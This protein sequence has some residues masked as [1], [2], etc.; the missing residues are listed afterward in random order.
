MIKK[1][2]RIK[3]MNEVLN[4]VK[5]IQ[6][7]ASLVKLLLFP[8]YY[9]VIKLYAWE[10]PFKRMVMGIREEELNVLKASALLNAGSSFTWTC[11]P[12]LVSSNDLSVSE[13][14]MFITQFY[15]TYIL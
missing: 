13:I 14:N 3:L 7:T 12:F 9:Q 8:Y 15:F 4:G 6:A 11:A 10:I 2:A 5:V 1:D